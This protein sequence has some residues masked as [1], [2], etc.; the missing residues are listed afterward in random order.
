MHADRETNS[1]LASRSGPVALV[2]LRLRLVSP[3][4]RSCNAQ[5]D[6]AWCIIGCFLKTRVRGSGSSVQWHLPL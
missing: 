2:P 3:T 6:T 5:P 1:G 4:R